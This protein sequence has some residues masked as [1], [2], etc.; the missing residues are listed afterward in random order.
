MII[1]QIIEN[2]YKSR[3][4]GLRIMTVSAFGKN[5]ILLGTLGSG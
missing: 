3:E 1:M 2:R 4:P 5:P